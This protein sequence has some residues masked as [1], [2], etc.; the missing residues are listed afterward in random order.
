MPVW[1]LPRLREWETDYDAAT[2]AA[3]LQPEPAAGGS[4]FDLPAVERRPVHQLRGDVERGAE[5][6][7]P[8]LYIPAGFVDLD[9][10][11]GVAV[12]E[13]GL[14][15]SEQDEA[16]VCADGSSGDGG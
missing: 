6:D 4:G 1:A 10:V 15:G 11:L 5:A 14:S 12:W 2:G 13:S 7:Y 8:D 9:W 16:I 3:D